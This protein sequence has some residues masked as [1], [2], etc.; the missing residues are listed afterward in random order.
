MKLIDICILF[1]VPIAGII[2]KTYFSRSEHELSGDEK[3]QYDNG[4]TVIITFICF[5]IELLYLNV[6]FFHSIIITLF[7][8]SIVCYAVVYLIRIYKEVKKE[9]DLQVS[10]KASNECLEVHNSDLEKSGIVAY[11]ELDIVTAL[12]VDTYVVFDLETT[13]LK[14]YEDD[15]IEVGALFVKNGRVIDRFQSFVNP[16]CDIPPH[17]TALTGITNKDVINAPELKTVM[18]RLAAFMPETIPV[19]GHNVTFDLEFLMDAFRISG[20]SAYYKYIDTLELSRDAFPYMENHKLST[21]IRELKLV[22]GKQNHRALDDIEATR[23]LFVICQK[24]L[25]ATIVK[26][27]Y[28]E[29]A[30]RYQQQERVP[31]VESPA[32]Y[33]CRAG[34]EWETCNNNQKAIESYYKAISLGSD[35]IS[36]YERLA[37]LLRKEKK[38]KE[39]IEICDLAIAHFANTDYSEPV[40]KTFTKRKEFTYKKLSK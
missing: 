40:S 39:E 25:S 6:R 31:L 38:Y 15:I 7:L 32:F 29:I 28:C 19:V 21:L 34:K 3:I 1:F 35:E 8:V 16:H 27:P 23:L 17:I 26:S 18:K 10:T 13:G 37:I 36:A 12:K 22:N 30:Q 14:Y 2:C 4:C 5:W 9:D 24:C 33:A 11:R 20:V